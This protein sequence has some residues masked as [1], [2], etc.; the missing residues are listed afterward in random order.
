MIFSKMQIWSCH[1]PVWNHSIAPHP[2]WDGF[3]LH[4]KAYN[5]LIYL[6]KFIS[7][8]LHFYNPAAHALNYMNFSKLAMLFVASKI[9]IVSLPTISFFASSSSPTFLPNTQA[10]THNYSHIHTHTHTLQLFSPSDLPV[11]RFFQILKGQFKCPSKCF[12][13]TLVYT[14]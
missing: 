7:Q 3:E 8:H 11:S 1:S 5:I 6:S 2:L 10:H 14:L 9:L 12:H 13:S 4:S